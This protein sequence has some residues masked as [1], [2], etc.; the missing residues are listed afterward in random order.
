MSRLPD[1]SLGAAGPRR[2]SGPRRRLR[3]R[4]VGP[5]GGRAARPGPPRDRVRRRHRG[6]PGGALR[7]R[8][9]RHGAGLV[10]A[11]RPARRAPPLASRPRRCTPSTCSS[12]AACCSSPSRWR[13]TARR[14]SAT[15]R[16]LLAGK[17]PR[18]LAYALAVVR[19]LAWPLAPAA[20]GD[21]A[22]AL[23]VDPGL[24][25]R[26]GQRAGRRRRP[27]AGGGARALRPRR[28]S[29][30]ASR[31]RWRRRSGRW[32]AS[33]PG[34]STASCSPISERSCS[35]APDDPAVLQ[36]LADFQRRLGDPDA[37]RALYRRV[38]QAEPDNSD[39]LIDLGAYHFI[40][41]DYGSAI[42]YFSDAAALRPDN[43]LAY[44][45]L[46][47]AYSESY[48]FT[49]SRRAL[50][51][52]AADRLPP[53]SASGCATRRASASRP[54]TAAS[55]APRDPPRPARRAARRRR[56]V[57]PCAWCAAARPCSAVFA[58]AIAAL[59]AGARP[60]APHQRRRR[61]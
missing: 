8:R 38:H 58:L 24:G 15:W 48:H 11:R 32:T 5:G 60:P 49:E 12:P 20:R 54:S 46:S 36:F 7:R 25:L 55:R 44:F 45:N 47:Q 18:P 50:E 10:A 27:L 53:G 52:G 22:G 35:L 30:C 13:S 59:A 1:L 37:A 61:G 34:A 14:C 28:R 2:R 21:V 41:R 17:V 40:K 16:G 3:P 56:A 51:P 23:L 39:V 42:R 4:P 43:A 19:L 57:A 33:S 31:W 26:R 9:G 6:P 29:G